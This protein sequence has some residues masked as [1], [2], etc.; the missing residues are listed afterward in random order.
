MWIAD[1]VQATA[2]RYNEGSCSFTD[3]VERNGFAAFYI[4]C[5]YFGKV[6]SETECWMSVHALGES[7]GGDD[8][9]VRCRSGLTEEVRRL[10]D[11]G[12]EGV[13]KRP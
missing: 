8:L 3:R 9:I 6:D 11:I 4:V 12:Q 5:I 1:A 7:A 13:E 10:L 2:C